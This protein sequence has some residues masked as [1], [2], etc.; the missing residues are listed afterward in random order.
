M[1]N[2]GAGDKMGERGKDKTVEN[3][4]IRRSVEGRGIGQGTQS[5]QDGHHRDFQ[6]LTQ[7]GTFGK[8]SSEFE[9]GEFG[10]YK[11]G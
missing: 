10:V 2:K 6:D 1:H 4:D 9:G 7:Q 11:R 3:R 5:I 8:E